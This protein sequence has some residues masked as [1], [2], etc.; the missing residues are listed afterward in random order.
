MIVPDLIKRLEKI[1]EI[2]PV[3]QSIQHAINQED[4]GTTM[5]NLGSC[6]Q[7]SYNVSPVSTVRHERKRSL[8]GGPKNWPVN[9]NHTEP[10]TFRPDTTP[11]A[12]RS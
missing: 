12:R 7:N 1:S 4:Y 3:A 5:E 8:I 9:Q 10:N 6:R 11:P 2:A